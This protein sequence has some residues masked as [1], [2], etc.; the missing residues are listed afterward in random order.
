MREGA[1]IA[2]A[3]HI[4]LTTERINAHAIAADIAGRHRKVCHRHHGGGA[5]A[6][7]GYA[8]AVIDC[9]IAA[10]GEEASGF[11][12][13]ISRHA[14]EGFHGFWRVALFSHKTRPDLKV[15]Q[16]APLAHKGF[17]HKAFGDNDMGE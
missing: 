8:Q 16:I 5:L 13:F 6:M 14:G 2:R 3:L 12:N 15:L 4:V 7:L 17:V 9:G 10:L 11:A 1:H